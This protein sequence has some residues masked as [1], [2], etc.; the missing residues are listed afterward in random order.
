MFAYVAE[1]GLRFPIN[2]T[3][4][5]GCGEAANPLPSPTSSVA[6]IF[7]KKQNKTKQNVVHNQIALGQS[8]ITPSQQRIWILVRKVNDWNN[9]WKKTPQLKR[10]YLIL[11]TVHK[12]KQQGFRK[13]RK[14]WAGF[15]VC[16]IFVSFTEV[17]FTS[18]KRHHLKCATWWVWQRYTHLCNCHRDQEAIEHVPHPQKF[19]SSPDWRGSVGWVTSLKGMSPVGFLVGREAWAVWALPRV[20]ACVRG[21]PSMFLSLDFSLPAPLS[22]IST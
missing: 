14:E 21:N 18:H 22:Q 4:W 3:G 12:Q 11:H 5:G 10:G 17:S 13:G 1:F 19:L 9:N 15:L 16:F 8:S 6:T 7:I 2:V 20:G